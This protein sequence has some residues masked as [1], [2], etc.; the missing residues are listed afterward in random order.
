MAEFLDALSQ[1]AAEHASEWENLNIFEML[2]S[3]SAWLRDTTGHESFA[4]P[5][6][7]PAHWQFV[8][9]LLLAGKH[10]E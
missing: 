5:E 7:P 4:Q 3:M 10:Y 1:D 6:L 8:A 9:Q 2:E